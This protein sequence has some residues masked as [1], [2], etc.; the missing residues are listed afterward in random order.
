MSTRVS[1]KRARDLCIDTMRPIVERASC[2]EDSSGTS[3]GL[4]LI[5]SKIFEIAMA[6][7]KKES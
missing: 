7:G 3:R 6:E 1:P 4:A 2:M 5:G